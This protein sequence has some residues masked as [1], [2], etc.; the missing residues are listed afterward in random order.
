VQVVATGLSSTVLAVGKPD[1]RPQ[2]REMLA[3]YEGVLERIASGALVPD[4]DEETLRAEAQMV[5]NLLAMLDSA[6]P[7]VKYY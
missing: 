6:E 7:G 3:W 4:G 2:L 1:I 5:N